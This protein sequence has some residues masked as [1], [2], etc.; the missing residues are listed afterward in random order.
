MACARLEQA[1]RLA[2]APRERAEIALEVAEAYAALFRWVETVDV[3]ERALAELG[4]A[5]EELAARLEGELV[6][7]GVH[8]ARRASRVAPVLE[9]LT[10]RSLFG[11]AVEARAVARGMA[12]VLAGRPADKAAAPLEEALSQQRCHAR[13]AGTHGRRRFCGA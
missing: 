4:A 11:S 6:V 1:L 2:T 13:R 12:M 3:I 9:R 8:D 10:S 5:H 7:C